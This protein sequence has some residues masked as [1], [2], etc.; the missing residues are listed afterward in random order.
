MKREAVAHLRA[1]H[2][3]SER[4][5][6]HIVG[7]DRTMIRYRP[8]RAP[9][10]VLRRRLRELANERSSIVAPS[11]RARW[12]TVRL[13]APVR[14]AASRGRAIGDPHRHRHRSRGERHHQRRRAA[15]RRCDG[16]GVMRFA[17]GADSASLL[18]NRAPF[19]DTGRQRFVDTVL[20]RAR[21]AKGLPFGRP[22]SDCII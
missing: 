3:L 12:T 8:Q 9:D 7:A 6:C 1:K 11:V 17:A 13:S 5:A 21:N 10:T 14:S 2:G 16:G 19:A 20:T 4:R 18:R 22:S 15:R